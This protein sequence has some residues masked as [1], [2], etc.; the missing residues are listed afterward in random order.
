MILHQSKR[1]AVVL[2]ALDGIFVSIDA[3]EFWLRILSQ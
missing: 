1:Y 2:Q 3:Q